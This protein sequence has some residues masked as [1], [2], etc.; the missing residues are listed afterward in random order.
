VASSPLT[1]F[2]GR[3]TEVSQV[4]KNLGSTRLVTLTGPGGV[5]K[6]R[7]AAEVS[8]RLAGGAWF[9][10]LAP[11]TEPAEVVYAVLDTLG[12]RERVISR[13]AGDPGAGPLDRLAEA[14]ADR[15]D[16]V[17]LDNCEHVIEAAAA[18]AGRVL[19]A[20]P[21]VR[22]VATSRQP[23]RIDGETLCP[24]P[25]L[26]VP[27]PSRRPGPKGPRGPK[28]TR[29]SG[30]CVT[31]RWPSGPTSSYTR[32]T[33]PPWPGSAA[34]WTGCRWPSNWPPCGCAR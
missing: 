18:L 15:D 23:L 30:C 7:L 12:I 19:A 5:G 10:E 4:L 29:R 32:T 26:S 2:V 14:L 8:G 34:R 24:V 31:G 3:D 22:I 6:T 13:R 27:P 17:I 21:R 9:V 1:S 11:V 20:C 16:V 25:P 33:W 28:P